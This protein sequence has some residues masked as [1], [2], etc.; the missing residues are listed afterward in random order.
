M[1]DSVYEGSE[2]ILEENEEDART[3]LFMNMKS[4]T[5]YEEWAN[6]DD[7][8]L[9]QDMYRFVQPEK[10]ILMD[11]E[12]TPVSPAYNSLTTNASDPIGN[13]SW[14][15]TSYSS[16]NAAA[17]MDMTVRHSQSFMNTASLRLTPEEQQENPFEGCSEAARN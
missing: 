12:V 8:Q 13:I 14:Y 15:L 1:L 6:G 16:P 2:D 4:S 3:G 5:E 17:E 10:I 11:Y 7:G 9:G